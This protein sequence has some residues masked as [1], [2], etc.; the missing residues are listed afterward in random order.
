MIKFAMIH[1]VLHRQTISGMHL[2]SIISTEID[3]ICMTYYFPISHFII[4]SERHAFTWKLSI[5]FDKSYQT[6][7]WVQMH[8]IYCLLTAQ[9]LKYLVTGLGIPKKK[10]VFYNFVNF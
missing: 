4:L 3:S 5:K 1:D 6:Y 8:I 7:Y 10:E 9:N 2:Y